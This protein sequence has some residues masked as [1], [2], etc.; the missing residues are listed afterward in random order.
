[1]KCIKIGP[2]SFIQ[3]IGPVIIKRLD[4]QLEWRAVE[5]QEYLLIWPLIISRKWRFGRPDSGPTYVTLKKRLMHILASNLLGRDFSQSSLD[6]GD[7]ILIRDNVQVYYLTNLSVTRLYGVSGRMMNEYGA[8]GGIRIGR[9]NQSTRKTPAPMPL[10]PSQIPHCLT[11]DR[12]RTIA[13]ITFLSQGPIRLR[14]MSRSKM[15]GA[16]CD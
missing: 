11:W 10:F 7:F 8:V 1:M 4:M 14:P 9:G 2:L 6:N 15:G 5:L 12:T 13:G 16:L 3:E